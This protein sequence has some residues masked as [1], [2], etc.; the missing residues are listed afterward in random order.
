MTAAIYAKTVQAY[1]GA[2]L[3]D[4]K[5]HNDPEMPIEKVEV[6][7]SYDNG[8]SL[9]TPQEKNEAKMA[10]DIAT[11]EMRRV[12][13]LDA[14]AD[15]DAYI[16]EDAFAFAQQMRDQNLEDGQVVLDYLNKKAK[17]DGLYDQIN[18]DIDLQID[19]SNRIIDSRINKD[20]NLIH[21][22]TMRLN[23]RKVYIVSGNVAKLD[24]G[25]IDTAN[26]TESIIV[27]DAQT[28]KTE[29]TTAKDIRVA[30]E[31]IDPT[32]EKNAA[33]EMI[34]NTI[35]D[36]A[37]R[38]IEGILPFNADDVYTFLDEQG[39]THNIV[40]VGDNGDGTINAVVD[41]NEKPQVMAK[42]DVQ[43]LVDN[44]KKAQYDANIEA[45]KGESKVVESSPNE[46]V[47]EPT[48]NVEQ[49]AEQ[50]APR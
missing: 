24:D 22:A 20:D 49:V 42:A 35:Y 27:M 10:L 30:D 21:P 34:T 12:F 36:Q 8:R 17:M 31:P 33:A 6:A 25:T 39:A 5:M 15:V 3:F 38:E 19:Q 4:E 41:G 28:G 2:K 45:Q 46:V 18:D 26:S 47:A 40:V 43:S 37:E 9:E 50:T 44:T 11:E 16:G 1:K 23:D 14:D 29:F 13:G 48:A 7:D 32:V